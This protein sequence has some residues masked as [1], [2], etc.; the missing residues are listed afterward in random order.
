MHWR[1][2]ERLKAEHDRFSW[3]CTGFQLE[4]LKRR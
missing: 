4:W 2:F 1:T 3:V